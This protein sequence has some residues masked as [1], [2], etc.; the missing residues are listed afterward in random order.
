MRIAPVPEWM[1]KDLDIEP[2]SD[3]EKQELDDILVSLINENE[4]EEEL[5]L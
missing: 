4:S 1:D 5:C 2:I 3:E